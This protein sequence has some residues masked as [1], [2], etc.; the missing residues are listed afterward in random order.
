MSLRIRGN[1]CTLV[2]SCAGRRT[3]F[4]FDFDFVF[5]FVRMNVY[6]CVSVR[7]CHSRRT[8]AR[9]WRPAQEGTRA[10]IRLDV[11]AAPTSF[12]VLLHARR[13]V[14]RLTFAMHARHAA[15]SSPEKSSAVSTASWVSF[16]CCKILQRI[17]AVS[18]PWVH[19][20][21]CATFNAAFL[22]FF[23][24]IRCTYLPHIRYTYAHIDLH[25][26][27]YGPH[28]HTGPTLKRRARVLICC[29]LHVS[30]KFI[31]FYH[32]LCLN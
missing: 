1:A 3:G 27:I 11:L 15:L 28:I 21:S 32:I 13:K 10:L 8:P 31:K 16:V 19:A 2:A 5:L 23:T 30:I 26:H 18:R 6:V 7:R 29:M 12:P 9:W 22:F 14:L 20:V 25:E 17:Q 4:D 24:H